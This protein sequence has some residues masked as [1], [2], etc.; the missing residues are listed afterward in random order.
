MSVE[1]LAPT[2]VPPKPRGRV[3]VVTSVPLDVAAEFRAI[4]AEAFEPLKAKAPAR[5]W[6][7]DDE[8]MHE[9]ADPSVLKFVARA[10]DGEEIV[11]LA[12]M[13]TDLSTVPWISEPYFQAR[14]PEH[15]SRDAIYYLGALLVRPERQ[16]GPWAKQV[17]DHLFYYVAERRGIGCFDCCGFNVD[18]V[19]L[20]D[21]V[22]RVGH[23]MVHLDL[24]VLDRQTYYAAVL[25]GF[26]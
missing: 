15:F 23:R 3:E 12:L 4:Y 18:R 25:G 8:F 6:L 11:A 14:F 17:M 10:S 13:S 22:A 1:V 5:Q 20:P 24:Q 16:G 9:M 21:L 2:S 19:A 26:K 7:T